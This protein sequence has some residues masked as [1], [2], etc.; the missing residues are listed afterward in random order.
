V[1]NNGSRNVVTYVS[2]VGRRWYGATCPLRLRRSDGTAAREPPP[3]SSSHDIEASF[4]FLRQLFNG[5]RRGRVSSIGRTVFVPGDLLE[6]LVQNADD[7][8]RSR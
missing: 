7:V 8:R 1:A 5:E 6:E 2:V 3:G 4:D